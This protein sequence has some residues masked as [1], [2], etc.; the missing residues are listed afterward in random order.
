IAL[1]TCPPDLLLTPDKPDTLC[2]GADDSIK[3]KISSYVNNYTNWMMQMSSDNGVTWTTPGLDTLG[4]PASGTVTPVYDGVSGLYLDTVTRYYRV[5][6]TSSITI[7]RLIVASTLANLT[8]T[9]CFYTTNQPKYVYGVNCMIALPTT[10][11]SFRGQMHD[12][13]GNLQW[14]T[15]NEVENLSY[16]VMRSDDGVHFTAI[17]TLPATGGSGGGAAYGFADPKPVGVQTYYRIDMVVSSARRNSGLV[18]LSNSNLP[19]EVRSVMNPFTD[20]INL[21][22]TAPG[23]GVATIS[24]VDMYGRYLRRVRQSLTQGLNS[25]TLYDLAALPAGTY[26]LQIQCN[27]QLV[28]KKLVKVIN[29]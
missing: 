1:S 21:E 9:G 12:G 5:P 18:L 4:R 28:S 11:L 3:F 10:I 25:F 2:Q 14:T 29:Q 23:D 15:S 6:A 26:A 19:F 22:L 7:Y 27:D 8:T 16:S 24:L 17:A 20:H 13:L